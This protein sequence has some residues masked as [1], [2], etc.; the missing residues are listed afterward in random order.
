MRVIAVVF[1]A[2][3]L[4]G[5]NGTKPVQM[6]STERVNFAPGGT[7]RVNGSYGVLKV[8]GWDRPEV[9]V[10]V[11]KSRPPFGES[12]TQDRDERRL[13][14]IHVVMN[15]DSPTLLTISTTLASRHGDWAPPL[16]S[17]TTNGVAADYEIHVPRD[18]RLVIHHRTGSVFVSDVTGDI[19]ASGRRGDIVLMLP[20]SSTYSIDAKTRF[21]TVSSD[22]EGSAKSRYLVGQRFART[23]PSTSRRLYLRMGF[24]GIT[25]KAVPP[26]VPTTVPSDK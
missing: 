20:D 21:G 3:P 10:T 23:I 14:S 4:F 2:W 25:I 1:L 26:E 7:I 17:T 11:T 13:E 5:N 22:F 24:G 18:S 12:K 15:R 6:T 8:E 9:E 16:P 19:E